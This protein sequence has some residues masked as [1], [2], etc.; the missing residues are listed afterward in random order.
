MNMKIT[1]RSALVIV[2]LVTFIGANV[3][4]CVKARQYMHAADRPRTFCCQNLDFTY[5]INGLTP[6]DTRQILA[7]F[8]SLEKRAPYNSRILSITVH[9]DSHV[10]IET[11]FVKG[12]LNGGG[13]FYGFIKTPNGW[14][15]DPK[16]ETCVW[17]S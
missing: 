9:D 8:D 7:V 12:P 5:P 3:Y 14:I 16:T 13:R 1:M 11:G 2:T 4:L 6:E 10:V 17:V 15:Y